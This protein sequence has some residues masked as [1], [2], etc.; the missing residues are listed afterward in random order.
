M[1]K[2]ALYV[3]KNLIENY[4]QVGQPV[5]SKVLAQES[6]LLLSSAS[7]RNIMA[8]LETAGFLKSPHTSSGR[9]PTAKGFR[10]FVDH[11][12][13]VQ[14]FAQTE[15]EHLREQLSAESDAQRLIAQASSLISDV[16]GLVGVVTLPKREKL[17]LKQVEF[18]SLSAHRV[19]VILVF[20]NREVQNRVIHTHRHYSRSELEQVGNYL[21][22]HFAGKDLG[23]VRKKILNEMKKDQRDI[24]EMI[25]TVVEMAEKTV[26]KEDNFFIS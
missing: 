23:A 6:N 22:Q 13:T 5:G 10:L 12:V 19:L 7:I 18:L 9:I 4:I 3:L 14:P 8:E 15:V 26:T 25:H 21:T 24:D 17:I 1:N 16:T 2:R 20:N 11:F